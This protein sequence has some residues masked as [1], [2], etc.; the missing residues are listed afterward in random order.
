[1]P[2]G[3]LL[4]R[5][6]S[7]AA[8]LGLTAGLAGLLCVTAAAATAAP[9]Y[10]PPAGWPDL[11][12][13]TLAT[14][15]FAAGAGVKRQ[16]YVKPDSDTLAEYD[17]AFRELSAKLGGKRLLAIEDDVLLERSGDDADAFVEGL[18]LGLP[19]VSNE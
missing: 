8:R 10:A 13:M 15:D 3:S 7:V 18:R 11:G 6:R 19:L 14:S 17:R 12:T 9:A 2:L 16:G 4:R 1:M 5:R